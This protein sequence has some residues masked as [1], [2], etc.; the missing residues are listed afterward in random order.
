MTSAQPNM[1]FTQI[2]MTWAHPNMPSTQLWSS[3]T[4]LVHLASFYSW[5]GEVKL[6]M[7]VPMEIVL[8]YWVG[9]KLKTLLQIW[10]MLTAA[11][12][13]T[14]LRQ[15]MKLIQHKITRQ[16]KE[17]V[18]FQFTELPGYFCVI[19]VPHYQLTCSHIYLPIRTPFFCII[20]LRPNMYVKVMLRKNRHKHHMLYPINMS[21][22]VNIPS[23]THL[24][25]T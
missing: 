4:S 10:T 22:L 12:Y 17:M 16:L 1:P 8:W 23:N 15:N 11:G 20:L 13:S 5:R 19:L 24:C 14:E 2:C 21:G 25:V 3:S 9:G 7:T 6:C 18:D